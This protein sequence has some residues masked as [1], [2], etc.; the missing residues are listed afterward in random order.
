MRAR[1][2]ARSPT[3]NERTYELALA[4]WLAGRLASSASE[5]GQLELNGRLAPEDEAARDTPIMRPFPGELRITSALG[6]RR[7]AKIRPAKVAHASERTR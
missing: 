6:E 7:R 5:L 1:S 3:E 4:G 2:R